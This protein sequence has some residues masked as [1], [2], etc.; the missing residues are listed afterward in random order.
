MSDEKMRIRSKKK[1]NRFI[2][3]V[4]T[5]NTRAF[6]TFSTI[7]YSF[8]CHNSITIQHRMVV[9]SIIYIDYCYEWRY[10]L[11]SIIYYSTNQIRPSIFYSLDNDCNLYFNSWRRIH[12]NNDGRRC[13]YPSST[14]HDKTTPTNITTNLFIV[15]IATTTTTVIGSRNK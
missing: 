6:S 14:T 3:S 2:C 10:L 13:W 12:R 9:F 15:C 5:L 8:I 1:G 7:H 4:A 11:V